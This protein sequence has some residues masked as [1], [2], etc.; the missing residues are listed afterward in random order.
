MLHTSKRIRVLI[1]DGDDDV[2]IELAGALQ[3]LGCEVAHSVATGAE[4]ARLVEAGHVADVA[5]VDVDLDDAPRAQHAA[6]RASAAGMVVIALASN[7][8]VPS[9]FPGEA[10]V[11]KPFSIYQLREVFGA[12]ARLRRHG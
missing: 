4:A 11:A 1:A 6:R 3:H 10:I 5:C 9:G 8:H 12:I 2:R 7:G